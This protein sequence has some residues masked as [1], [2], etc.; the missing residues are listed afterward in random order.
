MTFPIAGK[1]SMVRWLATPLR[2]RMRHSLS[3][4]SQK[5]ARPV[6]FGRPYCTS[7][8]VCQERTDASDDIKKY[9]LD[10][11]DATSRPPIP[12]TPKGAVPTF[13]E[14][15]NL[16]FDLEAAP[17][18]DSDIKRSERKVTVVGCGQVG[19]AIAYALAIQAEAQTVALVDMNKNRLAGEAKDLQQGSAFHDK[20]RAIAS[21]SYEGTWIFRELSLGLTR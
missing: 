9:L 21:S 18:T 6:A 11:K 20:V 1:T 4:Q 8:T 13:D 3:G 17:V 19:M 12:Y 14:S 10:M 16:K 7:R 5:P 2:G 15:G